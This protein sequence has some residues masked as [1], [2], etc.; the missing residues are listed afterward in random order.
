MII[1]T[2]QF[3]P[4]R[5][6]FDPNS[7]DAILNAIPTA[8]GWGP[9]KSLTEI[10]QALGAV[11]RGAVFVRDSSGAFAIVAGTTTALYKFNQSDGSWTT[12]SG[13][14]APYG[15]PDGD[16]WCFSVYGSKLVATNITDSVQIYDID[17]GGNFSDLAGSPPNARYCSVANGYLVLANLNGL[18]KRARWSALENI[19]FWTVGKR[20]SDY[21]DLA[22]GGDIAGLIGDRQG[23]FIFQRDRVQRMQFAP[24]SGYTFSFADVDTARGAVSPASIV[25]IGNGDYIYLSESGFYRGTSSTPIG[26][27]KVDRWFFDNVD[28]DFLA[29]VQGVTDPFNK[30]CWFLFTATDATRQMIGYDWQL[31]RWTRSD[32]NPTILAGLATTAY[33][34][35]GLDSVSSSIDALPYS[36]DSRVWAGGRPAF[37]AFDA[38]NKLGF[39]E[40]SNLAATLETAEVTL[41]PGRR[42]LLQNFRPICDADDLTGQVG[43]KE[44]EADAISWGSPIARSANTG[45]VRSHSSSRIHK[46]RLNIAADDVWS[47]C[48]GVEPQAQGLGNQ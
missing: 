22:D 14:S 44:T 47:I 46:I 9:F 4:D 25:N 43:K 18:P 45:L 27:E 34:L 48:H 29:E 26:A 17:A 38:N 23:A 8:D 2:A 16:L 7:S 42:T 28:L 40:G 19:E 36:L 31:G 30:I 15:V 24:G 3:A 11:C 39:F 41:A 6:R 33:T 21:Q 35:E 13:S 10:S 1:P 5:S 12:I 20:G 32:A 37:A